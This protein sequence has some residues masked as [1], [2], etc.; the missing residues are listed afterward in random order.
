MLGLERASEGFDLSLDA[1]VLAVTLG[2]SAARGVAVSSVALVRVAARGSC[3]R[4]ARIRPCEQGGVGNAALA[5][6]A[7]R[8]A[9][10]RGR[11]VA[12]RCGLADEKLLRAATA[13]P[14]LRAR[15]SLERGRRAAEHALR[16]R[17]SP[18]TLLRAGARGAALAPGRWRRPDSLPRCRSPAE[19]YGATVAID[20]YVPPP[21]RPAA[22]IAAAQYRRRLFRRARDSRRERP[23]LRGERNRARRDRR[24]EFRARV[25]AGRQRARRACA[26]RPSFAGGLVYDRRRRTSREARELHGRRV[27]A[28]RLLALRAA[29]GA[30]RDVRAAHDLADGIV[31]GR[32]ARSRRARG[33]RSRAL[34]R[35]ADGRARAAL[36]RSAARARWCS[37]SHSRRS[38]LRLR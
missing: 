17:R 28:H 29:T 5:Q 16:R 3:A 20:G 32:R 8:H 13:R 18:R 6:R 37:R 38:R 24:R 21:R 12:R 30:R 26:L 23:Q 25:L 34:R 36:A 19:N 27:R 9:A 31:D 11:R 35:R 4:G 7:R 1:R 14:R 33:S 22:G 15:G 10:C 2:A